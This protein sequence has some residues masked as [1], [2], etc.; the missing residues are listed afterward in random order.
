MYCMGR[1]E[2]LLHY[3]IDTIYWYLF[4]VLYWIPRE[5]YSILFREN[6][7]K[8]NVYAGRAGCLGLRQGEYE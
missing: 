5:S 4:S 1:E 3:W 7:N 6:E 8:Q 2:F